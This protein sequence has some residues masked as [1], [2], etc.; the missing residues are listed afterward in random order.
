MRRRKEL[1]SWPR[2][3]GILLAADGWTVLTPREV[4]GVEVGEGAIAKF[5]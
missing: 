3:D 1:E 4:A 5:A 2:M